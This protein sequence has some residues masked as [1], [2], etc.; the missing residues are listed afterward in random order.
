MDKNGKGLWLFVAWLGLAG[1]IIFTSILVIWVNKGFG[2]VQDILSPFNILNYLV[3]VI[4]L[5]P[6]VEALMWADK[7]EKTGL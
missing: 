2:V 5:A 1:L 4:I 6:G 3:T 7:Q